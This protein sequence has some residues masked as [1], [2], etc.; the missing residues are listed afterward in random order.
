MGVNPNS[1]RKLVE[2]PRQQQALKLNLD[3][4]LRSGE[5]VLR[6]SDGLKAGYHTPNGDKV[7]VRTPSLSI[8]RGECIALM[9]PNGAG[10]TTLMRTITNELPALDGRISLGV[11]VSVGYYAQIHEEL[12]MENTVL[13]EVHRLKP[14]EPTQRIRTLLGR[15]LFTGDDVYKRVGD[16]SG[17]ERSRV[18]LAQLTLKSPNLLLLDEPTNHL[19]IAAREALESV[20]NDFPGSI[21]FVSHDRYFVDALADKLWIVENGT[22]AQFEGDY[23]AYAEHLEREEAA[24]KRAAQ[25]PVKQ[26]GAPREPTDDRE[27]RKR[28]RQLETLE[29]EIA[30]LESRKAAI[31]EAINTAAQT[32]DVA[33][34]TK[35]GKEYSEVEERLLD[36]YDQWAMAAAEA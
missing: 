31:G 24:R 20:L 26:N 35:L 36:T 25:V 15:F 12:I 10:K 4:Q 21:L 8:A 32:E 18:A 9:G 34:V 7:L 22:V 1:E 13:E 11:N 3:T 14:L 23:T 30:K 6:T 19:D 16:L 5:V 2:A 17:G 29:Q 27:M 33:K 28:K